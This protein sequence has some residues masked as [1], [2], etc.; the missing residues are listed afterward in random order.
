MPIMDGYDLCQA[1]KHDP[2]LAH[3][4][5]V[6]NS[7]MDDAKV[8][9]LMSD[10]DVRYFIPMA[11]KRKDIMDIVNAALEGRP[12]SLAISVAAIVV[13]LEEARA[14]LKALSKKLSSS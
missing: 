11:A 6:M 3:I 8:Q 12:N 7:V 5:V 4:P 1:L 14:E 9:A 10:C 13:G 2:D